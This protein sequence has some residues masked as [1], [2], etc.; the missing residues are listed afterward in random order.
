MLTAAHL[1][2]DKSGA[3]VPKLVTG[4]LLGDLFQRQNKQDKLAVQTSVNRQ[5]WDNVY[6]ILNRPFRSGP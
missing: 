1:I 3:Q 6:Q 5:T 2:A 4:A